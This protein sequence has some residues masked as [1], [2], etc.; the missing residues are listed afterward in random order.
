MAMLKNSI[1]QW[2]FVEGQ[3][4]ESGAKVA[5]VSAVLSVSIFV[6]VLFASSHFFFSRQAGIVYS[7]PANRQLLRLVGR[8]VHETW[9][10]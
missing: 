7:P 5:M 1:V 4:F 2:A 9:R 10:L 3:V 8:I 6:S